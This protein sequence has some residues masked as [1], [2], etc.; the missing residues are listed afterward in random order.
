MKT[1][2]VIDDMRRA[3][4]VDQLFLSY[5]QA[6]EQFGYDRVL[7]A[8]LSDHPRL[9]QPA[10]HGIVSSYP[11]DWVDYYLAQDYDKIDPVRLEIKKQ[12]S[13]FTWKRLQKDEQMTARQQLLFAEA[14]DAN[15]YDGL[16]MP[17][18]GPEGTNAGIGLASSSKGVVCDLQVLWTIHNLS[19]QFYANYWR[20]NEKCSS[21]SNRITLTSREN[22]VLQ[23]LA[24]GSTKA[25]ISDKLNISYH[26]VDYHTRRILY[27]FK[28]SSVT[29]AVHFATAQGYIKLE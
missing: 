23:W 28:T 5:S 11:D 14:A 10:Q 12:I 15:L 19:L 25:E 27:K 9:Q 7:L 16:G 17:L 18:H 13:P 20:L 26:T 2:D 29:A 6:V 4:D 22:E 24:V 21:R 8:L 1:E 3:G